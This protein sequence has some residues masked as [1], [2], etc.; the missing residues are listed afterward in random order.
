MAIS[1]AAKATTQR[2]RRSTGRRSTRSRAIGSR[3]AAAITVRP[4]TS[5]AG[6]IST[7]AIRM[8]K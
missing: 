8:K 1:T 6:V 3:M 7:T 4:N 2:Q 5:V